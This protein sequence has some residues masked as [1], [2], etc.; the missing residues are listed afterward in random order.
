VQSEI[1]QIIGPASE[2]ELSILMIPNEYKNVDGIIA[3]K[4]LLFKIFEF[5]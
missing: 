2:K 1:L 4:P 5:R 3:V